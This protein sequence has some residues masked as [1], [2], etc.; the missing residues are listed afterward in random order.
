MSERSLMIYPIADRLLS[1]CDA[2]MRLPGASKGGRM[3]M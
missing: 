2:V 1:R 3:K